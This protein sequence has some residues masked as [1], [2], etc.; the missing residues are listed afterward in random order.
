MGSVAKG[1]SGAVGGTLGGA[2][3][4]VA[5][6]AAIGTL[7]LTSITAGLMPKPK[8]A[9]SPTRG[10][11]ITVRDSDAPRRLI[12]GEARVGGCLRFIAVSG[13]DKQYL[14]LVY[15]L[16]THRV[17]YI[18]AM[19]RD[20]VL[21][22]EHDQ[23]QGS[24]KVYNNFWVYKRLGT[25]VQPHFDELSEALPSKWTSAHKLNG[26]ACVYV[27][28]QWS[29]TTFVNGLGNF[30]W[31][32]EGVDEIY[33]P[34]SGN[35]GYSA[36]PALC[37]AH[38]LTNTR[39]GV[40]ASYNDLDQDDLIA[41]AN[42]CE[43]PVPADNSTYRYTCQGVADLDQDHATILGQLC[44]SMAGK[45]IPVGSKWRI[46]AGAWRTPSLTL[47]EN[48]LRGGVVVSTRRPGREL[49]NQVR[50]T[51]LG[52]ETKWQP[53]DF[54]PVTNPA[55][56]AEDNGH[57]KIADL[58]CPF[59]IRHAQARRVAKIMISRN[60]RQIPCSGRPTSPA[61]GCS[62]AT[63]S[64]STSIGSAGPARP[65]RSRPRAWRSR[66]TPT[67]CQPWSSISPCRSSTS[68]C[69]SGLPTRC[70][71]RRRRT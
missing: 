50:G 31:D 44:G 3:G 41:S 6:L 22:V 52:A 18:G 70:A 28:V 48:H 55:W 63:R 20:G 35:T 58:E 27:K 11:T 10:R 47:N 12:Y 51:F 53:A 45:V 40:G 69:S 54:I 67:A 61:I 66:T 34:R 29:P 68:T 60:R 38:Y 2:L 62:R 13:G 64:R 26:C 19:Y 56:L 71:R 15:V 4:A 1:I 24:G 37:I 8:T 36:N 23:T 59:I 32:I 14:H 39:F 57:E 9:E 49:F 17:Q 42:V 43:E 46:L 30:T 5:G 65:S 21:A 33:D 7:G 16:T 25:S